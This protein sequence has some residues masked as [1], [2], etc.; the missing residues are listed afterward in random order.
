MKRNELTILLVLGVVGVIVAFWIIVIGPKRQDAASLKEDVDQLHSQLEEAQQTVAAGEQAHHDFSV[1]YRRLV[2]L[3]KAVPADGDQASFLVQLQRLADRAG[4]RFQS[5]DLSES[6]G[7]SSTSSPPSSSSSPVPPEQPATGTAG[8]TN[9][10]SAPPAPATEAAAAILPIGASVGPAGLPVMPY[11]VKFTGG[12]FG[13]ADFLQSLDDMVH[14][15]DGE[16]EV[17]GRLLTVDGFSLTPE[18]SVGAQTT[19]AVPELTA[20]LSVTTYLTPTDQGLTAGATPG[21]PAAATAAPASQTAPSGT[22][23]GSGTTATPPAT[24]TAT[25]A[26]AP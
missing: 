12:F 13:I 2:L 25:T 3:G 23:A 24:S 5:I 16:V 4:V 15:R 20:D 19:T 14:T 11:D 26:T 22:T 9:P 17:N 10:I 18:Q 7:S 6:S 1:N 21:G 8:D